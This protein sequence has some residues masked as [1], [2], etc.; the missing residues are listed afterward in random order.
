M[1]Q[2]A[3]LIDG[4]LRVAVCIRIDLVRASGPIDLGH[5]RREPVGPDGDV[6]GIEAIC[7]CHDPKI[8]DGSDDFHLEVASEPS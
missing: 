7:F 6:H 5:D 4:I 1:L 8:A 2:M 3:S